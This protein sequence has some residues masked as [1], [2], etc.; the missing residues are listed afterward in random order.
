MDDDIR[1]VKRFYSTLNKFL[2]FSK[3]KHIIIDISSF[4]Y[5][6]LD[7]YLVDFVPTHDDF[8]KNPSKFS[9]IINEDTDTKYGFHEKSKFYYALE[10]IKISE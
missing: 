5:K 4:E 7:K 9:Y 8:Y 6:Y 2:K 10:E 1:E 3:V